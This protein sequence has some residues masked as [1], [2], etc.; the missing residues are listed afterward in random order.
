MTTDNVFESDAGA[1]V[2]MLG[3]R[4]IEREREKRN[5]KKKTFKKYAQTI[6]L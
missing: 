3:E 6:L 1:L 4:K 2:S 5:R